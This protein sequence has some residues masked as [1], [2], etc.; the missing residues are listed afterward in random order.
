MYGYQGDRG[1][2]G[3]S[4]QIGIDIYTYTIDTIV[5]LGNYWEHTAEHKELYLMYYG[6]L[7]VKEV[8]RGGDVCIC[9]ADSFHCRVE[10][11]TTLQ[12]NYTV[13][14]IN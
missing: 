11:N 4:C 12:C 7:T 13:I 2:D 5:W 10:M 14:K 9:V 8:Q 1:I 3:G 6:D